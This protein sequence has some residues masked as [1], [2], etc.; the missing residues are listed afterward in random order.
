M[1]DE[2][3]ND[4]NHEYNE[5]QIN[6]TS[7]ESE[8]VRG[9]GTDKEYD[10][11]S[12]NQYRYTN[13]DIIQD[14]NPANNEN[15]TYNNITEYSFWAEKMASASLE[16][17]SGTSSNIFDMSSE[18]GKSK[19][20]NFFMKAVKLILS[21]AVFGLVAGVVFVGFNYVYYRIN[22]NAIPLSIHIG[23][24]FKS[25]GLNNLNL[26]PLA[27]QSK[28]IAATTVSDGIIEQKTDVTEVVEKTMPSI[29]TITSTYKETYNW[30]GEE[31]DQ[32]NE[33][34]GSGIIVGENDTELLIAT[35]N[36][37][38]EGAS[39][40]LVSFIDN[41]QKE[42]IIKGTDAIADLAVITI[43]KKSIGEKTLAAIKVAKLGDSESVK[44]GQM[45]IAIGNALGYGQSVTVGYISA[46]DR[47]VTV[48]DNKMVLL[49]TDAAINPGNSGGALLNL[50]GEVIGINSVKLVLNDVEGMGYAIPISRAIPIVNELM[51][52]EVIKEEEKG[53]LGVYI[54]DVTEEISR[55]YNWP[56]GVYVTST[57]E[58]GSAEKAGIL[59]GDIITG[60]NDTEVTARVQ[61]QEKV[62]SYRAGTKVKVTLMR[63]EGGKY[64]KKE[65]YV[66][67]GEK[68]ELDE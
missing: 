56:I 38:V 65:I 3:F 13:Q 62:T 39:K 22:P 18:L 34:G 46:K 41:T 59:S 27:E 51:N 11:A 55:M 20:P 53:Y 44:V 45:A 14:S 16:Q 67:L 33:G 64:V 61:L 26:E 17:E 52:R 19:K 47:E 24:G 42:A 7:G 2:L 32:E 31:Y 57:V 66:T 15:H 36:H 9:S 25:I 35:N 50:D 12:S 60:I 43:D 58:D 49:Q 6:N 10:D 37:V 1:S 48:S 29:V 28:K 21:A 30:F 8:E 68:P 54:E 4:D 23:D 40:I 63:S 5:V